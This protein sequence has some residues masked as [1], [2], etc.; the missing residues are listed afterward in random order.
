M[1]SASTLRD[2]PTFSVLPCSG[3]GLALVD[4][5]PVVGNVSRETCPKYS[6]AVLA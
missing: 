5:S 4:A 6:Q 2:T 3:S 1:A